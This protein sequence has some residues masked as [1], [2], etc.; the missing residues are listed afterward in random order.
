ML[1]YFPVPY[2]DE[3]LYSVIARY[4]VHQGILANRII[5]ENLFGTRE[6]AAVVDFPGHLYALCQHTSHITQYTPYDWI[7]QHTLYPAFLALIPGARHQR[8]INSAKSGYAGNVHTRIGVSAFNVKIP[9]LLKVCRYCYEA[10]IHELGEPYWQRIFQLPGVFLCP[11]HRDFLYETDTLY[12]PAG[13][14]DFIPTIKA[15]LTK[16]LRIAVNDNLIDKMI[17]LSQNIAELLNDK[18]QGIDVFDQWTH[19]Y[20]NLATANAYK[21]NTRIDHPLVKQRLESYWTPKVL[22]DMGIP[23]GANYDWLVNL[24]R[25]HR[26]SFHY[27]CHLTVWQAFNEKPSSAFET[28]AAKIVDNP[29][30]KVYSPPKLDEL[31][32]HRDRWKIIC[33]SNMGKGIKWLRNEGGANAIYS[34]LFRHDNDWLK[35]NSPKRVKSDNSN[36]RIDW[37]K[38]DFDL[39]AELQRLKSIGKLQNPNGRTSKSWIYKQ[40]LKQSLLEK[41]LDQLPKTKKYIDTASETIEEFQKR[42]VLAIA[43]K[44][45]EVNKPILTWVIFRLAGIRKKYQTLALVEFIDEI[46]RKLDREYT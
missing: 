5:V 34:W 46:K 35:S 45:H 40:L 8:I 12:H 14:F 30:I 28:V 15:T 16:Q 1:A 37:E 38:R 11:I 43:L 36:A 20:K 33:Q 3:L 13:K 2:D 26:K 9:K 7:K 6:A 25:K 10:Q 18:F 4:G 22:A 24:F 23:L 21:H 17:Q 42:R 39:L 27:L 41:H 19:Y 29:K 32:T 44:L 31:N